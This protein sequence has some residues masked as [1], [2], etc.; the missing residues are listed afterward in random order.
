MEIE[1]TMKKQLVGLDFLLDVRYKFSSQ[2]S[3]II[4]KENTHR[5][6]SA[7]NWF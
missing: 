7:D 2:E 5:L 3:E 4:L 1:E 6:I